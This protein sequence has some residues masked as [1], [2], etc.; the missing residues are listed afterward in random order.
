MFF[1]IFFVLDL[2]L[3]IVN[4]ANLIDGFNGLLTIN[5]IINLILFINI[6]SGNTE[7]FVF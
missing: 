4:G 3:F 7:V 5:L 6:T 1:S 2:F